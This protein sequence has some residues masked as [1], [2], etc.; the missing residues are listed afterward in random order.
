MSSLFNKPK[1]PTPEPPAPM[2]DPEAQTGARRR[3][4]ARQTAS[5]GRAS[6]ILSTGQ[7]ETLGA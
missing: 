3:E 1:M 6:T 5:G 7:R 2:A 4:I